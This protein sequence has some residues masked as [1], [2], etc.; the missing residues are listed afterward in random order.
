MAAL[1]RAP[2]GASAGLAASGRR[3]VA[4]VSAATE[5]Q[6]RRLPLVLAAV[7]AA[8]MLFAGGAAA[9]IQFNAAGDDLP[10]PPAAAPV[11]QASPSATFSVRPSARPSPSK[12]PTS[13]PAPVKPSPSR[14]SPSPTP[15]RRPPV[16]TVTS[17]DG[18]CL[19]MPTP[20]ENGAK[21]QAAKCNGSAGQRWTFTRE[22]VLMPATRTR[23][24]DIGGNAGTDIEYRVQLWD[25]NFGVAQLWVPQTDGALFN[26]RSG[27]CLSILPQ[28]D[29]GPALAI[30]PCMGKASQRWRLPAG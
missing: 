29:G 20:D 27:R 25:C 13:K 7:V 1:P 24:L 11:A 3:S 21:V 10:D 17:A 19:T 22:G 6:R 9:A 14:T 18:R 26:A 5:R 4:P 30:L 23:C 12:Q 28:G 2:V 16:T 15:S 8:T